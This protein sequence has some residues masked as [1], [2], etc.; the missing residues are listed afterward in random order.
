MWHHPQTCNMLYLDIQSIPWYPSSF[1]KKW[2]IFKV[3]NDG[4]TQSVFHNDICV[5]II[6]LLA[7]FGLRNSLPSKQSNINEGN[8]WKTGEITQT[9]NVRA[10]MFKLQCT[11]Q[12]SFEKSYSER[13]AQPFCG[14]S[15]PVASC[16]CEFKLDVAWE[17]CT[18]REWMTLKDW[19]KNSVFSLWFSCLSCFSIGR[20]L[21]NT[22]PW[23]FYLVFSWT[24]LVLSKPEKTRGY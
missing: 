22:W 7:T 16:S 15:A 20:W 18:R 17:Q 13:A 3:R 8:G 1:I 19:Q 12:V 24:K 11:V 5:A 6:F 23:I 14:N 21:F 10:E 2:K 9:C 4:P